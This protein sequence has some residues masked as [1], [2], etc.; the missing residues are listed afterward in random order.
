MRT[1]REE[2]VGGELRGQ[3]IKEVE[4]EGNLEQVMHTRNLSTRST[5]L[6]ATADTKSTLSIVS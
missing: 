5:Y 4:E 2:R 3:M 6:Q 1:R